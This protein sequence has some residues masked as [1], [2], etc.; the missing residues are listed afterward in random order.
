MAETNVTPKKWRE[1]FLRRLSETCNI[2]ASCKTARVARGIAYRERNEDPA[3]AL[4]W[5]EAF[6]SAL[7]RWK[8]GRKSG[9]TKS[10]TR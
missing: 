6:N 2:T 5:D 3:F 9:R 8:I 1:V 7:M 4:E 10:P